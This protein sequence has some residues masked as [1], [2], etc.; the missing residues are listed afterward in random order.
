MKSIILALLFSIS[1]QNSFAFTI[2]DDS[3]I[4]EFWSNSSSTN[5]FKVDHSAWDRLLNRYIAVSDGVNL[6]S[7][8][9]VTPDDL[10]LLDNYLN[11]LQMIEVRDLQIEQQYA[12]WINLYNATT[13][14]IILRKYPVKSIL[15]I[16]FD[17]LSSGPWQE[18]LL[19]VEGQPLS[20]DDI[21]HEILRPLFKDNRIHYAVNCVSLSCPNLQ[22]VAFTAENLEELLEQSAQQ[23]INH[24]R[25]VSIRGGSLAVSSIYD[26]YR[27]DFGD[28]E[29]ELI[30][31][32]LV[33]ANDDLKMKISSADG[34]SDYVYDWALNE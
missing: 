1:I 9:D 29:Q 22:R 8:A 18:P 28:S 7:Y 26:W 3:E 4:T 31:H 17:L 23:Y 34:I 25:G 32:F 12:Y 10:N 19:K 2:F 14:K 20:L 13:V 5:E 16:S 24:P 15:D 33:Y 30:N 27:E 11:Q 21:E 6:F